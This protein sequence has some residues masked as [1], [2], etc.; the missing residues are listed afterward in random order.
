KDEIQEKLG[1]VVGVREASFD[2]HR[3]EFFVIMGLSGSG[4]STLI[5]TLIRLIEPSDGE[6]IIDGEDITKLD[7]EGL[8]NVR[9]NKT[10]MVFQHYGLLPHKTVYQNAE[11]GLKTRG[12]PESERRE[13][14]QSAIER[15]GL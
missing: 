7:E 6:I 15:V 10:A 2:V 5:R 1:A 12:I 9:R 3:S 8:R 4:K 14:A 13:K 11:Y